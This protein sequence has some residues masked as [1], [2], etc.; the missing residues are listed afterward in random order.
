MFLPPHAEFIHATM[1]KSEMTLANGQKTAFLG[2]FRLER[3][4]TFLKT[5]FIGT[6]SFW[7]NSNTTLGALLVEPCPF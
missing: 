3:R 1:A 6:F 2:P 7:Q 5:H 4:A